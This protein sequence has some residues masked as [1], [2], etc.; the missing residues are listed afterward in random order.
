[1]DITELKKLY[2]SIQIT[3]DSFY[4]SS[5]FSFPY[6]N[7][8]LHIH[9]S[10]L[11]K[12]EQTLLNLILEAEETYSVPQSKWYS[13][14]LGEKDTPPHTTSAIRM[15]QLHLETKDEQF[16][17]DLWLE[18]VR[19]LLEPVL[20]VFFYQKDTCILIQSEEAH[21]YSND[22]MYGMLQTLEEDFSLRTL[23][24]VGHYW[25]PNDSLQRLLL[26]ELAIFKKER[27]HV[28]TKMAT[29]ADIALHYFTAAATEQSILMQTLKELLHSQE[30][31]KE[32]I[33]A[34]WENQGNISSAAKSLY[35]H[36]NTLQY[37]MDKFFE[38]TGLS[39][40]NMNDLLLSYLLT[41]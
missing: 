33:H 6:K 38:L 3:Q 5:F 23:C 15:I 12:K 41:L 4:Q 37:R 19:N 9:E 16:D 39:L 24:Y 8:W 13:Y 35:I 2:P 31:W 21:L 30:D 27:T 10:E 26:E 40:K 7:K 20:D 1:L 32:I 29:L 14:L 22:E 17:S 25:T 11:S 28:S 36:R 34:L 18:S